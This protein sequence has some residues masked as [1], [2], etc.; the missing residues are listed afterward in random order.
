MSN[1]REIEIALAQIRDVSE[2]LTTLLADDGL[3][4][5]AGRLAGALAQAGR[6]G[7]ADRI[8]NTM[9]KA[10]F[11]VSMTNPYAD[12]PG[13][14]STIGLTR[15]R[16]PYVLRLKSMWAGWREDVLSIFLSLIHI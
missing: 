9:G 2:L 14:A 15:D 7:E 6:Q 8:V 4:T 5:S 10:G 16:S 3:P 11:K 1:P 13:F 12:I